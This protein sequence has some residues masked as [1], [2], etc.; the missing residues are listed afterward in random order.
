M[1]RPVP[2]L[3]TDALDPTHM[4][5]AMRAFVREALKSRPVA[6]S[7][8]VEPLERRLL[9]YH[10]EFDRPHPTWSVIGK[11]YE[12]PVAGQRS[13]D[14]MRRLWDAG[15]STQAPASVH[16]PQPYGYISHLRLLLMEEVPGTSL[17]VLVKRKRAGAEDMR[18]FAAGLAKLHRSA[19]VPSIPFR[20]DDHLAVRCDGRHDALARAF[21]DVAVHVRTIVERAREF[22]GQSD[23]RLTAVH[24]D[25]HLAQVHIC[26][27]QAWILDLD[28]LHFGDPAYDVAM[29]FVMLKHLEQKMQDPAYLGSLRATFIGEYFSPSNFDVAA[30]IPL[31]AALIH[32]KRAC[33]RFRYQDEPG[34]RDTIRQQVR[35]GAM[36]ME[37]MAAGRTPRSSSDIAALYDEC[38]VTV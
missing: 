22:E 8:T 30:R 1:G 38:P 23:A 17:K 2:E 20:V 36:C 10:V 35:E 29:V 15:F 13:F 33:K 11:V 16:I 26:D 18:L 28:P 21:P 3:A 5:A 31:H 4:L 14:G 24:G 7:V 34:W 37:K 12:T 19:A 32:L 25:F 9:R 27:G 6:R